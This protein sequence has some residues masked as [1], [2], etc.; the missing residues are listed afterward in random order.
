MDNH[1][2]DNETLTL[3]CIYHY[4]SISITIDFK[5]N[6]ENDTQFILYSNIFN[7]TSSETM[8]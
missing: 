5:S 6:W 2:I 8:K 4:Q 7:I 3:F 1:D